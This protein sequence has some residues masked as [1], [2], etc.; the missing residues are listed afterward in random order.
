[1]ERFEPKLNKFIEVRT[2]PRFDKDNRI[3][4]LVHIVVDITDRKKAE[5]E[6]RDLQAQLFQAQKM[7][8]IGR[9][10]GGVAHD[11]NNILTAIIGYS[12]ILL[13]KTVNDPKMQEQL[14][15]IMDS[16]KK[17]AMLTQ[18]LLA[19][20]RKQVLTMGVY[21]LNDIIEGMTKMITRIIGEDMVIEM[22]TRQPTDTI[23]ADKGQVEQILLNLAVNARDA[24]PSGGSLTLATENVYL[25]ENY[26]RNHAGVS[27]G[28]HVMLAV[29]DTGT[30]MNKEVL[31]RIFEPFFTTKD[32]G[33]GTGLG[34]ATVYG[35]VKQHNGHIFVYSEPGQG[36]AF[37]IYFPAVKQTAGDAV[38]KPSVDLPGGTETILVV[39]DDATV[40]GLVVAILEPLG[41]RVA[42]ASN[43]GE[44]LKLYNAAPVIDLLLTDVVMP[45]MN[46]RALADAIIARQPSVKVVFMSGYPHDAIAH[47]GIL[48]PGV[49]LIQKPL[50]GT[51][52]AGTVREVLDRA[53]KTGK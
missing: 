23:I 39:D 24:M 37:K 47:H 22:K 34:L 5:Q 40:R 7:E 36:T 25:D 41:Y 21:N 20:S 12:E 4:G 13:R 16:G 28:P 52:L 49:V 11:F 3:I 2:L 43:G 10:A 50:T 35:I 8:S 18:Q 48:D 15:I 26:A 30:G 42:A 45:G 29:S 1:M 33:K 19:M 53:G 44:A 27:P 51:V 46:G 17:A 14:S 32:I 9:L 31:D 6:N 38:V